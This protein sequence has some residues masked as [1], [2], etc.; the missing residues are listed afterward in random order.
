MTSVTMSGYRRSQCS[1]LTQ[2]SAK[3]N[4]HC[5]YTDRHCPAL[6]KL[7]QTAV[8]AA[9][10]LPPLPPRS[11]R[12]RPAVRCAAS[13]RLLVHAEQAR[14]GGFEGDVL[15]GVG[16]AARLSAPLFHGVRVL[17]GDVHAVVHVHR[18]VLRVRVQRTVLADQPER[19]HHALTLAAA[20]HGST[21]RRGPSQITDQIYV[22]VHLQLTAYCLCHNTISHI[23]DKCYK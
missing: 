5:T 10:S 1:A 14:H 2:T 21:G 23:N 15:A 18:L 4:R 11:C 6:R 13:P 12:R 17:G 20:G 8:S 19:L 3:T 9:P 16:A 22:V 7:Q